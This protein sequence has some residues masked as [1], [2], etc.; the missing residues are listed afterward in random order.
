MTTTYT[1]NGRPLPYGPFKDASGVHHP[2]GALDLW[3]DAELAARGVVRTVTPDPAPDPVPT[4]VP[5]YK[6]RKYLIQQ[7]LLGAVEAYLNALPEPNK[8]LALVDWEYAPNLVVRSPLALGA[9]AALGLDDE[10]YAGM[11]VAAAKLA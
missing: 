6:V 7:G 10:Q 9:K 4:Q 5:M 11:V 3:T 2:A 8:A 1:L